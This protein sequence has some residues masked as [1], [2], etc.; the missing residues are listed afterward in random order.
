MVYIFMYNLYSNCNV[1][2]NGCV[3]KYI[4]IYIYSSVVI[5]HTNRDFVFSRCMM[6]Q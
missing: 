3:Y 1:F 5:T 6:M 2:E 4:Y